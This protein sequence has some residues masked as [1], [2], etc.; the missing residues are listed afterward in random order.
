LRAFVVRINFATMDLDLPALQREIESETYR[1]LAEYEPPKGTLGAP[2]SREKVAAEL[3][4]MRRCLIEPYW[5]DIDIQDPPHNHMGP[6]GRYPCVAVAEDPCGYLMVF[7][8]HR[9]AFLLLWRSADGWKSLGV[10][11]DA[12]GTFLAR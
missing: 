7:M 11:G 2:W 12:V 9:D 1:Y 4:A 3:A 5:I 6:Y 8:P 10:D